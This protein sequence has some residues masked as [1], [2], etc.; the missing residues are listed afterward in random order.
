[1]EGEEGRRAAA[2]T[3]AAGKEGLWRCSIWI[4]GVERERASWLQKKWRR[5]VSSDCVRQV[6]FLPLFLLR[7]VLLDLERNWIC[8]LDLEYDLLACVTP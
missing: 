5:V 2:G 8:Y 3:E 7:L 6:I 1:M 4:D